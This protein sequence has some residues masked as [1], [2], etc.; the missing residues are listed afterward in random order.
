MLDWHYLDVVPHDGVG[1]GH[2]A[3]L[4]DVILILRAQTKLT[5]VLGRLLRH[6]V[7]MLD[8]FAMISEQR[9]NL[10]EVAEITLK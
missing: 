6:F 5:L 4:T 9:G 1:T 3:G 8:P 7:L 10:R 2:R